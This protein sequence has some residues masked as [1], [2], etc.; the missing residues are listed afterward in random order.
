MP[1][2]GVGSFM[3]KAA[4]LLAALCLMASAA[5]AADT[6]IEEIIARI[7]NSII[8]RADLQRNREQM[9][10]E[11][12]QKFGNGPEADQEIG[13]AEKN[14][15]RDVIDQQLLI[16][17]AQELGITGD[18]ELI[19][20]LDEIR[21]SM[22]LPDMEALE[23][24]AAAQGV[25]YEDFKQ[26]LRNQ[27][28]TQ[29]VIS[30]EVGSRIQ[31]TPEEVKKF[32]D[33]HKQEMER[34]ETVRLSEI[35]ISTEKPS[36]NKQ[37]QQ[38]VDEATLEA[39]QKT[40]EEALAEIKKGQ[41][42]EEVAKKYS[43]GPTAAQGGDLGEF[44]RG[45]LAK[46][47]EDKVFAMKPNEP[48]EVI[49]TKQGFVILEVTQHTPAGVPSL[50]D[51]EPNIQEAI[52]Y[53]KLQPELRKYL[54]TLREQAYIDIKPGYVDSGASPNQTKPVVTTAEV[55]GAKSKL[56]RKKKLGIF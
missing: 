3:R 42:F 20:K 25:S 48:S 5:F 39:A 52:Y 2:L 7:N 36:V 21:K 33:E 24:S 50:K 10:E 23:K 35:L 28:V 15:L 8:T 11:A 13:R 34:P 55:E 46:E 18:T 31:M 26:N 47:L 43:D 30:R 56:K 1:Q 53:Q 14:L 6:V 29:Q 4:V 19:K 44:K 22:N 9:I 17:K 45:T 16:Q 27:I 32:Y 38:P 54:T 51:V 40:A 49:R 37:G 41:K 12:H